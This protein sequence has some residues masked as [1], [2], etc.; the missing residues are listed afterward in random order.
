MTTERVVRWKRFRIAHSF[1][2]LIVLLLYCAT[3]AL[4]IGIQPV[5]AQVCGPCC[6]RPWSS[7]AESA[8][9]DQNSFVDVYIS[10]DFDSING[11]RSAVSQ[12][13]TNWNNNFSCSGIAF[14]GFGTTPVTGQG[15]VRVYRFDIPPDSDGTI[16]AART[17]RNS[18][19]G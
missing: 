10:T 1:T 11:G 2:S 9:P 15:S 18:G 3:I 8:W 14:R 17:S 4:L 16:S 7:G 6:E 5:V 19:L 13:F 12:A